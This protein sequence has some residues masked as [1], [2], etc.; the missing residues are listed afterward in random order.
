MGTG[1]KVPKLKATLRKGP[2]K[3]TPAD[4]TS[5]SSEAVSNN[6]WATEGSL[7]KTESISTQLSK[8]SSQ[9]REGP[10][11]VSPAGRESDN[12]SETSYKSISAAP[13]AQLELPAEEPASGPGADDAPKSRR[14]KTVTKTP[15]T[16]ELE[17]D[18]KPKAQQIH[19]S[20]IEQNGEHAVKDHTVPTLTFSSPKVPQD[21]FPAEPA[22]S[23]SSHRRFGSQTIANN[24]FTQQ[25]RQHRKS[26]STNTT[27]GT[28]PHVPSSSSP[29]RFIPASAPLDSLQFFNKVVVLSNG[30][31]LVCSNLIRQFH[32]AGT[33]VI[34]G[35]TDTNKARKLIS[36]LGPPDIVNF[37][38]CDLTKYNDIVDLFKLAEAMYGRVDHAIFGSGDD[39]GAARGI[40]EGEKLWGLDFTSKG[41]NKTAK[42]ALSE[43]DTE[44]LVD[45]LKLENVIAAPARFAR[46]AMAYL[47]HTSKGPRS[48]RK[49]IANSGDGDQTPAVQRVDRSLTF[50]TSTAAF[51]GIPY[52]GTYQIASHALLGVVRSLSASTTFHLDGVRVN[53]VCTNI[54]IP[55]AKTM[56]GGRMSVQLP[57]GR[58]EDV[59]RVIAG[60]V[61]DGTVVSSGSEGV[62][63]RILYVTGDEAVDLEDGLR[64]AERAW[65]GERGKE[66]LSSAEEGW[67]GEGVE[68]MLMDAFE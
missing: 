65:L 66:V 45:G 44:P 42:E 39:G 16:F 56:A 10:A 43:V 52:L 67:N 27:N 59:A 48:T 57:V 15:H 11:G 62:H 41:R 60:V 50:L 46:V 14:K 25:Q 61:A 2:A 35:D 37:N 36:S 34:F 31:S 8:T 55:T 63:G 28:V 29:Y 32:A 53:A 54:M 22:A 17:D 58:V 5:E 19:Q 26:S 6:P 30:S 47:K 49:S 64:K 38:K 1:K 33:R 3:E 23:P 7:C 24:P 40:G 4:V 68:W 9:H 21:S 18:L 12:A 20:P 51:K 13:A